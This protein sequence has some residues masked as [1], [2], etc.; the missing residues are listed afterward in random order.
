MLTW[1][2]QLFHAIGSLKILE[3]M[4]CRFLIILSNMRKHAYKKFNLG[5]SG[6]LI[7][8]FFLWGCNPLQLLQPSL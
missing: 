4:L 1:Y 7:L 2:T 6:W 3:D 8:L 5:G